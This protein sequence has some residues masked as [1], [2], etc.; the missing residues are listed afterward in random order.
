MTKFSRICRLTFQQGHYNRAIA[1]H[2][3]ITDVNSTAKMRE[4]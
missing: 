3:A 1:K 4:N 2:R